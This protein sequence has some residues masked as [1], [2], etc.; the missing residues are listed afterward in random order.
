VREW[1]LRQEKQRAEAKSKKKTQATQGP[2][3]HFSVA[4]TRHTSHAH[5]ASSSTKRPSKKRERKCVK[6]KANTKTTHKGERQQQPQTTTTQKR[7]TVR[8]TRHH[9]H[10]ATLD[11]HNVQPTFL[12]LTTSKTTNT[13]QLPRLL[14]LLLRL[15]FVLWSLTFVGKK[16][17]KNIFPLL[18]SVPSPRNTAI[19]TNKHKEQQQHQQQHQHQHH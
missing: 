5:H 14:R 17:K 12:S 9:S 10:F 19:H 6:G 3:R 8:D 1:Q 16:K 15:P 11:I 18:L 4:P 13:P 2:E 7:T